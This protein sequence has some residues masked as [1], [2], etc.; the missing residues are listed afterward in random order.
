MNSFEQLISRHKFMV[1]SDFNN[2]I[3]YLTYVAET[4]DNDKVESGYIRDVYD[5][6]F[7]TLKKIE[8]GSP[9]YKQ[10]ELQYFKEAHRLHAQNRH[11]YYN[12][13]NQHQDID[14]F[15]FLEAIIDI[16]QSQRQYSDYD[17][18][19]IMD[20]FKSKGVLELDVESLALNTLKRLEQLDERE[21]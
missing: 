20:T 11:H 3:S 18:G 17:L 2:I 4:H 9:E 13:I 1:K 8:F 19:K 21:I 5:T 15:D 7:P 12:P 14:L 6:H 16:R 10:Y